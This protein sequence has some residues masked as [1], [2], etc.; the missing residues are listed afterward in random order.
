MNL[1]VNIIYIPGKIALP[2]FSPAQTG[3]PAMQDVREVLNNHFIMEQLADL[4]THTTASDGCLTPT[5]VVEAAKKAGLAAVAITDH[6]T[7]GG[8]WPQVGNSILKSSPVS[9]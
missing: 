4:H 2:F 5:E 8:I 6:D 7:V 9:R 1:I 3:I